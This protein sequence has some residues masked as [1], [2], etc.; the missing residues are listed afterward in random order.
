MV[1]AAVLCLSVSLS[2]A[3]MDKC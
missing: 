1:N 2:Q 3:K